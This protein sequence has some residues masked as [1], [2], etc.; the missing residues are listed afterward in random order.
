[1]TEPSARSP[2]RG[3][4][5]PATRIGRVL[6][7]IRS[8]T[9]LHASELEGLASELAAAGQDELAARLRVFQGLHTQEAGM[10]LDELA[11]VQAELDRD[12]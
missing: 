9:T 3:P 2:A 10:I 4:L 1:L 7:Q 12:A 11:D 6:Q 5:H 8:F